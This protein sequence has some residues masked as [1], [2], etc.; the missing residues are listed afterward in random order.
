MA[1]PL[2]LIV[3]CGENR[4]I[5]RDGR[6]PWHIPEDLAFFR[7]QTAGQILILGRRTFESWPGATQDGRQPV[8]VTRNHAISHERAPTA[9]T[10]SAAVALAD[11]LAKTGGAEIFVCGGA[12]IYAE[13]LA[14]A[15]ARPL[16]LFLTLVH[17]QPE[18]DTHLPEWRHLGWREVARRTGSDAHWRYTFVTFELPGG[19]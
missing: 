5:G 18:G 1:K 2:N 15:G 10:F 8:V 3:A 17:G 9:P 14:L 16:R 19:G 11:R 7:R 13:A 6:L 4:V 12:Q